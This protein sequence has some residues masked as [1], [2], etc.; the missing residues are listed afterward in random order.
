MN[1]YKKFAYYYDEVVQELDYSLWVEFVSPYINNSKILDLACGTGTFMTMLKL[2]G[3]DVEGL[4]LSESI[5]EIAKEKAKI[6]HLNMP[7]YVMDMTEFNLNKK[8]DVITCFFDSINF[9]KTKE[10][11]N[12]MFG[13]VKKHLNVN[14]YFIFD[15]FSKTMF[16]EYANNSLIE[17]H[18]TFKIDWQTKK[19]NSSTL[20]HDITIFEGDV[21]LKESYYEYFHEIKSLIPEGFRLVKLCGDFNDN[22]ESEDERILIVL[23]SC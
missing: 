3:N 2:Q 10:Q 7:F 5:I 15:C 19:I 1:E 16:E 23:Q 6:N 18:H 11:L 14:G 17:D 20:K 22:L 12:K 21:I 8:Y 9:L 13:C 4:D